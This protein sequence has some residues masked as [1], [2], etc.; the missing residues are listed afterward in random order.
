MFEYC[1]GIRP[2]EDGGFSRITLYPCIDFT[3]KI[4]S[5][6]GRYDTPFGRIEASWRT[7]GDTATY[8]V[9]IPCGIEFSTD[10]SGMELIGEAQAGDRRVYKF[11]KA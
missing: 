5:A 8:E 9:E 1:L 10:F 3:G 7:D 11:K 2:S 4:T 6:N